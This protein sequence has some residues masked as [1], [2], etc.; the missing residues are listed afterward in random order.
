MN[1]RF[2]VLVSVVLLF[3][4]P[5]L[6]VAETR[7]ELWKQVDDAMSKGLPKTAV[8]K[9]EPIIRAAIDER[10]YAEAI[11]AIGRKIVLEANIQGN[12][13]EERITRL[14]AEIAAVPAEMQPVMQAIL[15]NWYWHYFQQNQWRF[16]Q[17][18][19]TAEPPG[20]DFTTWDLTRIFAEIDA[21]FT[22]ALAAKP[23]LQQTPIAQYSALLERGTAPDAYRPTL[24]DF[25]AHEALE[26]YTSGE[27]AAA[28]PS[29]AFELP[30]DGPIFAPAEQFIAWQVQTSDEDSPVYKAVLLY[31]DLLRFHQHDDDPTALADADLLRLQFGDNT[32]FGEE[33]NARYQAA[34][35]RFADRWGD[36][37]ISTRA[38]F[39]WASVLQEQG[40]LAEAH[41]LAARGLRAFPD[42][43]GGKLCYNVLHQ[44]EA[45]SVSLAT[46]RVWNEPWPTIQVRYRNLTKAHFRVVAWDYD[47]RIKSGNWQAEYLDEAEQRDLLARKPVQQWSVELPPTD[48]FQERLQEID[49]PQDLKPGFYYLV[50]SHAPKFGEQN[51]QVSYTPFWVSRLALVM[52]SRWGD[53]TLEGF[54]LEATSGQP[55]A[56]AEVRVWILGD[57]NQRIASKSVKSDRNGLFRVVTGE[58]RNYLI[59]AR[60]E[61]QQLATAEN[62]STYVRDTRETPYQRTFFFTDRSLYRP[63]QTIQ[64]KG[65]AVRVETEANRYEVL[66]KHDVTAVFQ[67]VNGEEIARQPHR[68]NDFGSFSGSF[69]APR[70]RLLGRMVIRTEGYAPGETA[71]SVEEYKRPKFQVA[72]D[73]P[74][75]AAR[76]NAA[77]S[78][79]GKATAYTGAAI[80]GAN[81]RWRV[82][83]EVRYPVW[84]F[85]RMWWLPPQPESSQEIARGTG[86]TAADGG[87]TVD[88]TAKPDP[89][90]P[91]K[92]E[93]TFQYTIYADVTDTAGETRS[94]ERTVNVGY[95]ALQ[96][97][98]SASDWQTV[99]KPVDVTV[100]TTTL[101]GEGQQAEGS[102]KLYRL[103]QPEHAQRA[104]LSGGYAP[105]VGNQAVEPPSDMSNPNS[106]PLGEV[107]AQRGFTTDAGGNVSH[108][109][110]LSA[111]AYRAVLE[112]QDRFG[113]RV[114]AEL[115]LQVLAP[116][117]KALAI[118]VPQV[119]AAPR[120]S[121]QPGEEF[122]ALWGTGYERGRAFI[123]IEHRRKLIQS[124]WTDPAD[125]QATI[126][127]R[128]S[129]AMRGGLTVR[130][131]MV[132]ENRA[133]MESR[134]VAVPWTN[135]EFKLRWERFTSKLLP[136]QRETWTL[137]VE[138]ADKQ[139]AEP[140]APS[141][142]DGKI[143]S[144]SDAS[145]WKAVAETVAALYD[146]SLD[147]YLPHDWVSGFGVF[148]QES[149]N[150]SSAF[151]NSLRSLQ[152]IR[153]HW[154]VPSKEV[155]WTYRALPADLTIN[156]WGYGFARSGG[157][158]LY[159]MG[160][161]PEADAM[162]MDMAAPMPAAP[163]DMMVAEAEAPPSGDPQ[164]GEAPNG[165]LGAAA[166][167]PG[168]DLSQVA[169]RTNLNE[170]AFFFPHLIAADKGEI[171]L[172]FSMPEALTQWKFL[173]FA[174]DR[175]LRGGL[176]QDSA[177]TA[178]DLMVQPN[179]P[180]FL[181]EGDTLEFTVKVSNQSP[182]RQTGSVRLTLA[183][184]RTGDSADALLGNR[185]TDQ[186]FDIPSQQSRSISWR[187]TVPD[188]AGYLTYKAVGSTGK[189]SDGEEG[190]LP[191]LSRRVLVTESLPLPIRGPQTREFE[192]SRLLASGDSDTL[193]H[194]SLTVQMVSNPAWY[195][196]MALPYLMDFP[197]ECTEQTFNR[198]YANALA[199]HIAN[200]DPKI[201]RVFDQWKGTPALD[202]PLEKNQDLK[203]VMLEETPWVREANAESQARRNVGIL[204]DDNRL[205]DETT[206][207][208]RNLTE[209]QRDDGAWPWFPGGPANEYMTLYITTGFGRLRHLGVDL[210]VSCAIRS[211]N[212]LD[213]WI[214]ETYRQILKRGDKDKDQLSAT[215][216]LYL[217]GRS[218]FLEDQPID[219]AQREAVDY[220]LAQARRYW[221]DLAN[222]QSQ[223]HLAIALKRF[224]DRDTP[225]A[226]MR[227]IRERSVSDDELGMFWRELELSWWWYRAPIE[228][229][230]MMI[231]AFDEVSD[232]AAAVEDCKV[233]L[234]KQKQT[235]DWKTTKATADAV[236]GL[237][238]RG[239][240]LLTSTDLVQV[241]LGGAAIEPENVEAGTG[242]YEKRFAAAEIKPPMG[243]ITVKKVDAGV[244]WGSVHWQYLEDISKVTPYDG[245]P[246]K[247]QKQLF[248]KVH[249]DK[250]P[251]LEPVAGPVHVGDELVTRVVVR[252]DRDMEYVHLKDHRG[253]GTEPVNVLSRYK[254][255]DGL[256][257]YETT[258][259]TASHF[260]I[261]YLPKGVYVFE[262]S[263][264]VQHRGQYQTG[265]A[266]IQ[267]MYAPEFNSHSASLPLGVE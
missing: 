134:H 75:A 60:H 30:A 263:V 102:L 136:G 161:A 54:V 21:R 143:E 142:G 251:A 243:E 138:P 33:K 152:H 103:K 156:L 46:E 78:L 3:L 88:F 27:Q 200:S 158:K 257:Y 211:L 135:K 267:C 117:A 40:Q 147:A 28:K 191:V 59:L 192:F 163:M 41:S 90:V 105:Y 244:A 212:R 236:Y 165:G 169:A 118:K 124:Y 227:S 67:D 247:L 84:W 178:K 231:E 187:L 254:Y 73:A 259:D 123:E 127:Q 100:R 266:Q 45:K 207:L 233:W 167:R 62:Y 10:A 76:L 188:G 264:R 229:Q 210:D 106:W 97:T 174:H 149:S 216:A 218:F 93:P 35:K 80:D 262:Y 121:L 222:R 14:Q 44:I 172:E 255:Q 260:F 193:R 189:L 237:L 116:D 95:T 48:D 55:I 57:R 215:I 195:A 230:A 81:V 96:A 12:R 9:L 98:L 171:R 265:T 214:D 26:F 217:Y 82:V 24:Y 238:L 112:T 43:V 50:A 86:I 150:L 213:A 160:D 145:T 99:G 61:D 144:R 221:L 64:Y 181:R 148:R 125:T 139:A 110:D 114:T 250:G 119:F 203:A 38:L 56:G 126:T 234:L 194:Q 129:E 201:R 249:T 72:L 204:F 49:A 224:G 68:T 154:P 168:P 256:A 173:G 258:R 7:D 166:K 77:V 11:K 74:Q 71:V 220:F 186:D 245:T 25:L 109:F 113:K 157:M 252:V 13:P 94:D 89:S 182:A 170:T 235:Q 66:A 6:A 2:A 20:E 137:V 198:L 69:T 52:R 16:M 120:W 242:F 17:R 19:A 246:L 47:Q 111:G 140:A 63:G 18:T 209:Q 91:E 107:V 65:I 132:R 241:T 248:T 197:Y 34:L 176:L 130:V 92:D 223:A 151:E 42:S 240:D 108:S 146:Q 83:R 225:Q 133:Y 85:W 8:E 175:Q 153:G 184:A 128:V 23:T 239:T 36:H 159:A 104:P 37:E 219:A 228:T 232:D 22:A 196:V 164:G 206:R 179:P 101:D 70:D 261:D 253:S 51:N 190:Y 155:Q 4:S 1:R 205:N 199:R 141:L 29:D 15:A 39:S 5:L 202:S 177:V 115:P 226:I 58:D 180:R 53:N 31:Q 131:T 208:L 32:A 87:F 183:D 185:Q 122:T 162:M 79:Q